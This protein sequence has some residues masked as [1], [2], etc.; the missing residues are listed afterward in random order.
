MDTTCYLDNILQIT[1]GII[2]RTQ[3]GKIVESNFIVLE[4][5]IL[6]HIQIRPR[7]LYPKLYMIDKREQKPKTNTIILLKLITFLDCCPCFEK[8]ILLYNFF[9]KRFL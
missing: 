5:L 4:D 7:I 3:N 9:K 6:L 2:L 1:K 8:K